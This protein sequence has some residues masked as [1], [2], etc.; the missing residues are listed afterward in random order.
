M[1]STS[2]VFLV[3]FLALLQLIA[4]LVHAHADNAFFSSPHYE[5]GR[6]HLPGLETYQDR[7]ESVKSK[8]GVVSQYAPSDGVVV[9]IN[10]GI[11]P[12]HY[13][14]ITD[15]DH[16]YLPQQAIIFT[17]PLILIDRGSS[18]FSP[19]LLSRCLFSRYSP[20]APPSQ[21]TAYLKLG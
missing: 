8:Y 5:T 7:Y 13:N 14:D 6:L 12:N 19:C 11:K 10:T 16:Y 3:I 15:T 18:Y 4:P 20:R 9:G 1:L 2:R 17:F 21:Y